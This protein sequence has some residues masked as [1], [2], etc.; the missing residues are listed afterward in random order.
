MEKQRFEFRMGDGRTVRVTLDVVAIAAKLAP[1]ARDSK[2][3]RA[4]AFHGAIVAKLLDEQ[5]GEDHA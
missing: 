4:T 2:H 1:R 5:P 3:G